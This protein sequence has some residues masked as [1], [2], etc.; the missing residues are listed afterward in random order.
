MGG[1]SSMTPEDAA[2]AFADLKNPISSV[3]EADV[4]PIATRS[5]SPADVSRLAPGPTL[6]SPNGSLVETY[7]IGGTDGSYQL[8]KAEIAPHL[9]ALLRDYE[10]ENDPQGQLGLTINSGFRVA[11]IRDNTLSLE[12]VNLRCQNSQYLNYDGNPYPYFKSVP[13]TQESLRIKNCA[14]PTNSPAGSCQPPTAPPGSSGHQSGI[15]YDFSVYMGWQDAKRN[16]APHRISSQYRWMS[17]NA[18]KY[19]F[20]RT[21]TSERWHWDF[22]PGAHQFERVPRN[23][24]TWDMQFNESISYNDPDSL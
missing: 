7:I 16:A 8:V 13:A 18:Y 6:I 22:Y 9:V 10:A 24:Y 11:F 12:E 20:I 19:G 21:V 5:S 14:D 2:S 4:G 3:F 1:V 17:L 15:S 23:H